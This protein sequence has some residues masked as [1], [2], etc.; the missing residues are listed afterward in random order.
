MKTELDRCFEVLLNCFC[1]DGNNIN[2]EVEEQFISKTGKIETNQSSRKFSVTFNSAT[3]HLL[4]EEFAESVANLV[5]SSEKG[6]LRKME[7]HLLTKQLGLDIGGRY[8]ELNC[9]AL[10]TSHEI[11]IVYCESLPTVRLI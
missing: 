1:Y 2:V 10:L 3:S 8:E 5:K 7:N 11:L 6:F 9:Y 4:I